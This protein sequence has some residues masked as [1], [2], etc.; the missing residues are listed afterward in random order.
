MSDFLGSIGA[1]ILHIVLPSLATVIA[2]FLMVILKRVAA[3]YGIEVTEK[4][5]ERL[6]QIVV[7]K[8]HATEEVARRDKT[9]SSEE[10][11]A[12]AVNDAVV[13][14]TQDPS[15]P[16]PSVAKV[17]KIVDS[18]LNKVRA[19]YMPNPGLPGMGKR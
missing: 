2:G 14:A 13:E 7:D 15:I 6:K 10:K 11:K 8:I 4:Q 19:G 16:N 9:L 5:E 18:E 12:I 17:S 1:G 3:K